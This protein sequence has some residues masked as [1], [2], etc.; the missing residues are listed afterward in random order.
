MKKPFLIGTLCC[1]AIVVAIVLFVAP[2]G[3][4]QTNQPSPPAGQEG[5]SQPAVT[6]S[7]DAAAP[8][9]QLTDI[10]GKPATKTSLAG[11]PVI[12]WFTAN[13][14]VPC[15]IAAKEIKRLDTDMGGSAFNVLMVFID[16]KE[17]KEDLRN[18]KTNYANEDWTM[19]FG[20]DQMIKEYQVRF[21]DTQRLLDSDGVV[22]YMAN[23]GVTYGGYKER[24]RALIR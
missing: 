14:C 11:K 18:W 13:Y 7:I 8:D 20:N 15:Q 21:L 16:P 22:R 12:V 1:G 17:S 23:G 24:I 2:A 19:A 5:S 4:K 6:A 10:D 3:Q 9:F